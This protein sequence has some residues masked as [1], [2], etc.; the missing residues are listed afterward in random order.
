MNLTALWPA[1]V[2]LGPTDS[3]RPSHALLA[4]G[5][6][7]VAY[8]KL[9]IYA[10]TRASRR[11]KSMVYTNGQTT[12]CAKTTGPLPLPMAPPVKRI[13][14]HARGGAAHATSGVPRRN[15]GRRRGHRG[16]GGLGH[17]R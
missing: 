2:Q 10:W 4:Y 11:M 14:S 15:H 7:M 12:K 8:A 5:G 3:R 9:S 1:P 16:T 6:N 17:D 13:T